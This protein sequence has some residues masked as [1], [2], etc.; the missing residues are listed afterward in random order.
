M[1]KHIL[2]LAILCSSATPVHANTVTV[3]LPYGYRMLQQDCELEQ[4]QSQASGTLIAWCQDRPLYLPIDEIFKSQFETT[5]TPN[6]S[7]GQTPTVWLPWDVHIV[8]LAPPEP[9]EPSNYNSTN[10]ALVRIDADS[11]GADF[12]F[13]CAHM[14]E[15]Q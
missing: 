15:G 8:L 14:D 2:A 6:P 11:K 1:N 5:D 4:H 3:N 9:G 12:E 7:Q 10:C 13:N